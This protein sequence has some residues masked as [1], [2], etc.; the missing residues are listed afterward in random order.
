LE[1]AEE[2]KAAALGVLRAVYGYESF[3]GGQAEVIDAVLA[4]RDCVA[5]MPTGAGKSVTFQVPARVLGGTTLVVSPLISLMQDQVGALQRRG[6]AA[7]VVNSAL[8]PE[9][10]ALRLREVAESRYELVYVAPEGLEGA[11]AEAL[12]RADVRLVAVDE[13][14]CISEWGHDFRPAYRRLA[15]LRGRFPRAPVLAVT[16]SATRAVVAD[17][18]R[19]LVLRDPFFHVASFFRPNLRL[20]CAE[21][22]PGEHVREAVTRIVHEHPGESG[23]VYCLSR[24]SS[25][26]MAAHLEREGV[27]ALA[28]HAGLT[29]AER[30]EVQT[31]FSGGLVPVVAA[32]IAFGMGID[33]ADVRFV[34]H[35]DLPSGIESYYQEVGRAGRDGRSA[36]CVLLYSWA[37]VKVRDALARGLP[38]SSRRAAKGRVRDVYRLARA[39]VCRHRAVSAYFGERLPSCGESCDVC[40]R[41]P[42]RVPGRRGGLDDLLE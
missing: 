39:H 17:I 32:T 10:R 22:V 20:S 2:R 1:D 40:R 13:A 7:A 24:R 6:F 29:P 9:E 11:A 28:Y 26:L 18:A 33:K 38:R 23:I 27:G 14:H 34:V 30:A 19:Q 16:A 12:L 35:R 8:E 36:E 41:V 31:A 5:V 37:D 15:G 42:G 25:D 21:K 4:G 3:R